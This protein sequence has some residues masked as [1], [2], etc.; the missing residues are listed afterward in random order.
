[1]IVVNLT[2]YS[3]PD[4]KIDLLIASV[5]K[6]KEYTENVILSHTKI[7]KCIKTCFHAQAKSLGYSIHGPRT[8]LKKVESV[9]RVVKS[10]SPEIA[11]DG[12]SINE[13]EE[14][15]KPMTENVKKIIN[16]PA[17]ETSLAGMPKNI[18]EEEIVKP[19]TELPATLNTS[20][21]E[22]SLVDSF[23]RSNKERRQ[24]KELKRLQENIVKD[25][26]P[27]RRTIK[28]NSRYLDSN[29]DATASTAGESQ[30]PNKRK[31]DTEK[32]VEMRYVK[33]SRSLSDLPSLKSPEFTTSTPK[34]PKVMPSRHSNDKTSMKRKSD[35]SAEKL[36][37]EEKVPP[38]KISLL[39][40]KA[41]ENSKEIPTVL[42]AKKI[43]TRSESPAT[44][45][46]IRK[47]PSKSD[48]K[49]D[50][51]EDERFK[52]KKIVL[53][54]PMS[55]DRRK[56]TVVEET[57]NIS[58]D[59]RDVSEQMDIDTIDSKTMDSI[60]SHDGE[61]KEERKFNRKDIEN[62]G[63]VAV[64]GGFI[65]QCIAEDC[66]FN[67][68]KKFSFINHL[69]ENHNNV[70]WSGQCKVCCDET[71]GKQ[72]S[73][74]DEFWH[75][76]EKHVHKEN[77]DPESL[78]DIIELPKEELQETSKSE[79]VNDKV[80]DVAKPQ[81]KNASELKPSNEKITVEN[82]MSRFMTRRKTIASRS[83]E[84]DGKIKE[85]TSVEQ[86][87]RITVRTFAN[88][89]N[90][91]PPKGSQQLASS[92]KAAITKPIAKLMIQPKASGISRNDIRGENGCVK[93]PMNTLKALMQ[94]QTE[95]NLRRLQSAAKNAHIIPTIAPRTKEK[96]PEEPTRKPV[97]FFIKKPAN[98]T[99]IKVPEEIKVPK[100]QSPKD[101]N[102]RP[103][104]TRP[105][106]K[107]LN[108]TVKLLAP[109]SLAST[110]KCMG[111]KCE[112]VHDDPKK[113]EA[114]LNNHVAATPGDI[115]SYIVCPYCDFGDF[116][117]TSVADLIT[118]IQEEHGFDKYQCK[119]CFY[120]SCAHFNVIEHQKIHH[121]MQ[122]HSIIMIDNMKSRD[123]KEETQ[124]VKE[125][126]GK[127][128]KPLICAS[129][130]KFI[131]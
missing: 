93:K 67:T 121:R 18:K 92:L 29:K 13:R 15:V 17:P 60:V 85:T 22:S 61:I 28:R 25:P 79:T 44:N 81:N 30:S 70:M 122:N 35:I 100:D 120:R 38:L 45:L 77:S 49:T 12:S 66:F 40:K 20:S 90:F 105:V 52:L 2:S 16:T 76:M 27:S 126:C 64:R 68:M 14:A 118:H 109:H 95:A 97:K 31:S 78:P 99:E 84:S 6:L 41:A 47:V 5:E 130:L 9:K 124:K 86:P 131:F 114:H 123:Y 108:R 82:K 113:F 115:A 106:K 107:Y 73:K 116:T 53:K 56:P 10:S 65:F 87:Q 71:G 110:F 94:K 26:L 102:L 46:R 23:N 59:S 19:T 80:V 34:L 8:F 58:D 83:E 129:K 33:S 42:P 24:E 103:W 112:F 117:K 39:A 4:H 57:K 104:L 3:I 98:D 96:T 7:N 48:V 75:M 119:Y 51:S 43:D 89:S 21:S 36:S 37:S 69:E 128:I 88:V 72:S 54:S 74:E 11:L 91:S 32:S 101:L 111:A 1:M 50:V 127:F 63:Y 125:S 62:M 55:A